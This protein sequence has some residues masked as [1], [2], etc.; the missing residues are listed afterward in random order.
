MAVSIKDLRYRTRQVFAGLKR[1]E[2]QII[3]YRGD[4]IAQI[5]PLDHSDKRKFKPVGY[6]M[7]QDHRD[8]KDVYQ[9]L[10]QQRN[11]RHAR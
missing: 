8:I 2:K 6:G 1:G 4:P 11:P 3:S 9:W 7:W 5:I 10:D